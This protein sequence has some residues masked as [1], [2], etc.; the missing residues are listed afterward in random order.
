MSPQFPLHACV[1][2]SGLSPSATPGLRKVLDF[3]ELE[4]HGDPLI[5]GIGLAPYEARNGDWER[6]DFA[7]LILEPPQ[8]RLEFSETNKCTPCTEG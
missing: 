2:R 1:D 6:P 7:L 3:G 4:L 5:Q 8:Q